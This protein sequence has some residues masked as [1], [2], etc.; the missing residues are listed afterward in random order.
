LTSSNEQ[1]DWRPFGKAGLSLPPLSLGT[2]AV[3]RPAYLTLE[4]GLDI[5]DATVEGMRRLAFEVLDLSYAS[6]IRHVDTAPSYGLAET[7]VSDWLRSRNPTDMFVTTKWGYS[8]RGNWRLDV[9]PQ[10]VKDLSLATYAR[11]VPLSVRRFGARLGGLQIH[12]ATLE[13][14][15]LT[16]QAVLA[17]MRALAED[18]VCI[19]L[20]TSGPRQADAIAL[21]L[22]VRAQ[23]GVP[24]SFIQTTWNVLEPSVGSAL[25]MASDAGLGVIIKEALANGRLVR[26]G[27]VPPAVGDVARRRGVGPDVVCL[28]AALALECRPVVLLGPSTAEQLRSNLD[29]A[30]IDLSVTEL[31]VLRDAAMDPLEY[32]TDRSG[33]PWT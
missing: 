19:G 10:E 28:A 18:G 1:P 9:R 11:Q 25:A 27:H 2:A 30:S 6:G 5:Q 29:A 20:S 7:F 23:Q 14:G 13:S 15:V 3:G 32:W 17:A 31:A 4:H 16:D 26:G 24:F 8:Y 22:E 12:S 33:L 21:A